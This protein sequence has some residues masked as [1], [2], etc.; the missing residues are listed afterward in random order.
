MRT[1]I[2]RLENHAEI[3]AQSVGTANKD[4]LSFTVIESGRDGLRTCC[5][6]SSA[7]IAWFATIWMPGLSNRWASNCE[8]TVTDVADVGDICL[9]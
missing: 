3:C 9:I 5:S 6:A 1:I 7:W 8:T 4:K 2:A